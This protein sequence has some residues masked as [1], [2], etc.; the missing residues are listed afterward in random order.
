VAAQP[1]GPSAA[2][3]GPQAQRTQNLATALRA[4][5]AWSAEQ[6]G[7]GICL[8]FAAA[9]GDEAADSASRLRA[10]AGFPSAQ[11]ARDA[12]RMLLPEV[13]HTLG[14]TA[15]RQIDPPAGLA[16]RAKAGLRLFPLVFEDRIHGVLVVGGPEPLEPGCGEMLANVRSGSITHS[17]PT[18]SP[19]S[20]RRRPSPANRA[21]ARSC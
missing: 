8:V 14:G 1:E 6:A 5:A 9:P 13:H 3:A 15:P 11:A 16:A 20:A 10:A 2:S 21:R 12:A 18:S 19:A 17:W 7:A 4:A